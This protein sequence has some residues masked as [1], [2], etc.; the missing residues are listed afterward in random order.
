MSRTISN[1]I[2]DHPFFEQLEPRLLLSAGELDPT[3]GIGGL[4]TTDFSGESDL[5]WSVAVQADGKIVAAGYSDQGG[6]RDFALARYNTDGSPDTTFGGD[7]M[8]TTDFVDGSHDRPHSVAIQ[9]DGKIVVVGLTHLGSTYDFA[10][11]RYNTDGSLDTTFGG[12]GKVITALGGWHDIAWSVA[13]DGD[14]KIVVAGYSF[15][16]GNRDLALARYNTDG[17]LD[18]TFG[19]DGMVTSNIGPGDTAHTVAIQADGKIVVAGYAYQADNWDF[20]LARYNTDGSLDATF[21]GDGLLTTDFAGAHDEA[22]SVAIDGDGRIVVT[23]WSRQG[24]D[25]D[26]A[27]ARYNTD[28]SLDATFNGD[29]KVTTDFAGSDDVTQGLAIQAN[30]K[31]VVA[32]HSNQGGNRNFALARYNANGSLDITFD[33]DGKVTTDFAGSSDHA[34]SVV[35]D[36]DGKIVVAGRSYQGAGTGYDFALARYDSVTEPNPVE[37][38][39]TA[40]IGFWQNKNGQ[41]L[42]RSLNGDENS[43]LLGDWLAATFPN[44]YRANAGDNNLAG[45]TNVEVAD[46]YK[47]IFTRKKKDRGVGGPAKV[48]AHVMAVALAIYVTNQTL[49]EVQSNPPDPENPEDPSLVG[50]VES[51]GFTVTKYGLGAATFNVGDNGDAFGVSDD[52]EMTVL[53]LLLATDAMTVDGLLYDLDESGSIDSLEQDLRAMA[54]AVY[55]DINEQGDIPAAEAE[56]DIE[57]TGLLSTSKKHRKRGHSTF[58]A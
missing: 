56:A 33:G 43:T 57:G 23:G 34:Y 20:A 35:I 13:I 36:G 46:F 51:Y 37:A 30:G 58:W 38:G 14:G 42:I 52:T 54:N 40:T 11:A 26:F 44:M 25:R 4:V 48:D 29:G 10:L 8:V 47:A 16:W 49:V 12:D 45:K 28:G 27:L 53:D 22:H 15:Q 31:I 2:A 5:A 3:F 9:A 6:D 7:G 17:S 41:T 39:Q 18:T 21:D 32:G 24:G 55:S 19:G 1:D 50:V